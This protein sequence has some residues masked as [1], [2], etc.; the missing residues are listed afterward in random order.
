MISSLQTR[1]L[2][3]VGILAVAAVAAV[4]W[5]ARYSTRHEFQRFQD[6]E[7]VRAVVEH[8][9]TLGPVAAVLDGACCGAAAVKT[10]AALLSPTEALLVFDAAGG[11]KIAAGKDVD[12]TATQAS[13]RDG[14]L[15]VDAVVDEPG[16]K[17]QMHVAF[18]G[19]PS[20]PIRFTDGASGSVFVIS[21]PRGGE[22][23]PAAIFLGSVDRQLIYATVAIA[24][25]AVAI[26]WGL[27]RRIVGPIAELRNATR[28]LAGGN[29]SR[30]V[31]VR[32][33]DE[34][35]ELARGFN[36]MAEGLERQHTLRRNLVHDVAHELR[37]P[38]TDIRC[39]VEAA[40]DGLASDP[41]TALR[42]V[43]EDV[44]HLSQL[45][46]DL[47]DLARVEARELTF[48][49]S[50]VRAGELCRSALRAAG[51]DADPRVQLVADDDLIVRAD[52]TRVRQIVI[53]FLT[54][55]DRHTPAGSTIVVTAAWRADEAVI[56]VRNTGSAIDVD[57]LERVFDRFYRGDPARQRSTGGSGLGLA[58]AKQLAEAQGGR[59]WASSDASGVTF[60][61]ALPA[62]ADS[63]R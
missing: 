25:L 19:V 22:L 4:A 38:L 36:A 33:S 26:T 1:L 15:N 62:R 37:T 55:A 58:I 7:R 21:L 12:G 46:T 56:E 24:V 10:A 27:A 40:I 35:A 13:L 39:R 11:L 6:L 54:N 5:S 52:A 50:E 9:T 51:L 57:A 30:R 3:A 28:D 42:Q 49:L 16:R 23:Q 60:G 34:V 14:L 59:V 48:T 20:K 2:L 43:N 31:A 17:S 8:A 47:E 32:G 41:A 18:R 44:T 61:L 63:A 29:L 45:V 53:N